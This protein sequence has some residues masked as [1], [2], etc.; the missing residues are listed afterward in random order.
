MFV[1][2]NITCYYTQQ[3]KKYITINAHCTIES[4]AI[5]NCACIPYSVIDPDSYVYILTD[6]NCFGFPE[7]NIFLSLLLHPVFNKS[8]VELASQQVTNF[9]KVKWFVKEKILLY[10]PTAYINRIKMITI[11]DK[12]VNKYR[13]WT[14]PSSQCGE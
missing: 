6:Q 4:V 5:T 14:K 11:S 13:F 10:W 12:K 8:T 2:Y 9:H 7:E 1:Y 3:L